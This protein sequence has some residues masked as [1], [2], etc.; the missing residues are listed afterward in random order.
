MLYRLRT[1][2]FALS[3]IAIAAVVFVAL[4]PL[5]FSR[6][7][8]S[9]ARQK[10]WSAPTLFCLEKI[11]GITTKEIGVENI[12]QGSCIFACKHQSAWEVF[13]FCRKFRTLTFVSKREVFYIPL[14]GL[15]MWRTGMIALNRKRALKS[16]R[17]L[18]GTADENKSQKLQRIIIFPEGTRVPPGESRPYLS[19]VAVLAQHTELPIVPV[20]LNSGRVW[21]RKKIPVRKGEIKIE[22]LPPV[23]A[24]GLSSRALRNL[25]QEKIENACKNLDA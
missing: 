20:A 23:S 21:P 14:L 22:F 16:L 24:E 25:L 18:Q 3:A 15:Y 19:G 2:L 4:L 9:W 8:L 13:F 11:C 10:L 5:C 12:P 7:A 17:H 1:L 6:S